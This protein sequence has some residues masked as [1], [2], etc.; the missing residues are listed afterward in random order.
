MPAAEIWIGCGGAGCSRGAARCLQPVIRARLMIINASRDMGTFEIKIFSRGGATT[1]RKNQ[2]SRCAFAA[3]PRE[4]R[5][6][7]THLHS[8]LKLPRIECRCRLSKSRQRLDARTE[9]I[10]RHP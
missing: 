3:A 6:L 8:K 2:K 9:R 1:Q 4:N 10:V 5:F 7:E